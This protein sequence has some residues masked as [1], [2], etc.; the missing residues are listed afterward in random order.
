MRT[1][2]I[3]ALALT[4]GFGAGAQV[5]DLIISEY[6]EGSSG[7]SKY[8]EIYNGTGSPVTLGNYQLWRVTNG[9]TW[10]EATYNFPISTLADGATFVLANNPSDVPGAD[11][12]DGFCTWNG[13]DAVG[14]AKNGSLLD[15]VGEDGSDPGSGWAVAGITNG[16][17]DHRLTRKANV[18]APN[19]D[20][21][22]SRG[23]NSTNSEWVV[24][25]Y[26]TGAANAGHTTTCASAC[27]ITNLSPS[28]STCQSNTAAANTDAVEVNVPYDGADPNAT[29]AITV[30]SN[31]ATNTGDDPTSVSDGLIQFAALEGQSWSLSI[32]GG[33]C[34]LS[35]SGSLPS[36]ACNPPSQVLISEIVDAADIGNDKMLELCNR[37]NFTADISG[38][39]VERYANGASTPN[40]TTT[41]LPAGATLAPGACYVMY[42]PS[43]DFGALSCG[44][45]DFGTI[46]GNGNDAYTLLNSRGDRV[47]IYGEPGVDGTGE[48]WEYTDGIATRLASVTSPSSTFTL[49]QWTI[50][51]PGNTADAT[52]CIDAPLSA[53]L[54]I[55]LTDFTAQALQGAVQLNWRT[56]SE[57]NNDYMVVERSADA[58]LYTA[59]GKVKGGG[60]T[61]ETQTYTFTDRHPLP[62]L[63][64]YR[65]RQV[66]FDGQ[67]AYHGPLRVRA[68]AGRP[69]SQ[70]RVFP[71][72]AHSE[73][74][75]QY[76]GETLQEATLYIYNDKGQHWGSY[77][78]EAPVEVPL[79][80]PV[81]RL[82]AGVYAILMPTRQGQV[83]A[84]F[85]KP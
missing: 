43:A 54:P 35:A 42:G 10:P 84:R 63:Q 27:G 70:L 17:R 52:P 21:S 33:S 28:F 55:A 44:N 59:L 38:W 50:T 26:N 29:L 62:G 8:V 16:T 7:N 53:P 37:G 49:S 13:N 20:W 48:P 15:A 64:F 57:L 47:D 56:T 72:L 78:W 68:E 19:T 65:L 23:T 4:L 40:S 3:T 82:P 30:A 61:Q 66:D 31:V 18:C 5:S 81:D 22:S 51:Q 11:D 25:A 36:N 74:T 67:E 6:G 9:G 75:V 73:L 71:T 39:S 32:S 69:A 80:I 79:Q 12:T 60:T 1:T 34:S 14:L 45:D 2:L 77:N 46:L 58:R 76:T 24:T 41:P 85:V 83:A